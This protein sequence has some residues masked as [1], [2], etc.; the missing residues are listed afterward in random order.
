MNKEQLLEAAVLE[1]VTRLNL[2]LGGTG[3][4]AWAHDPAHGVVNVHLVVPNAGW[5]VLNCVV[6]VDE[7]STQ[8]LGTVIDP[9]IP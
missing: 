8:A 4:G 7:H 9:T 6:V 5:T 1:L 3:A 2:A